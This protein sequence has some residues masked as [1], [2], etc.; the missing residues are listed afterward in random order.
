MNAC[1]MFIGPDFNRC[2]MFL[3]RGIKN[4]PLWVSGPPFKILHP[5]ASECAAVQV[6]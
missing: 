6:A 5:C 2:K 4:I 1:R 3:Q